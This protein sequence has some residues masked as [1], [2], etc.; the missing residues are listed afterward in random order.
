MCSSRRR[1]VAC[2]A[3]FSAMSSCTRAFFGSALTLAWLR[4]CLARSANRRVDM[5]SSLL[6]SAGDTVQMIAVCA[7]PPSESVRSRVILESRYG[8]CLRFPSGSHKALITLP[9]T[10][11]DRLM[12]APSFSLSPVAPVAL[13]LSLPARSTRWSFECTIV[14]PASSSLSLTAMWRVT[15]ACEREEC[16]FMLVLPT[17]RFWS[18][19]LMREM[20]CSAESTGVW[21]SPSTL[22]PQ[23]FSSMILSCAADAPFSSSR[24][25]S[26]SL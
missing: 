7:L 19:I 18:P 21:L 23:S 1:T 12:F 20:T 11:S 6:T 10:L 24:S 5:V 16:S 26:F 25:L 15:T 13:A 14:K 3:L 8:T 2:S 22:I 17:A 9:S 4:T